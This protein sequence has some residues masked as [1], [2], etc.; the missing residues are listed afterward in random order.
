MPAA[1]L[2]DA[3]IEALKLPPGK[4]RIKRS[5]GGGLAVWIERNSKRWYLRTPN[6]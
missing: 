6:G 1:D 3:E 2:S 4:S 5:A